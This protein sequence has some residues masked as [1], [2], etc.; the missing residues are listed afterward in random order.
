MVELNLPFALDARTRHSTAMS[1]RVFLFA[2]TLASAAAAATPEPSDA[3]PTNP[4]ARYELTVPDTLD[5]AEHMRLSLNALTR[6]VEGGLAA[7]PG[8]AVSV[9]TLHCAEQRAA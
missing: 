5:L 7:I 2:A 9:G 4:G 1:V 8:H 6:C 3:I